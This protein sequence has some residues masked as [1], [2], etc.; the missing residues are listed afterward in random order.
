MAEVIKGWSHSVC[1]DC[2]WDDYP[3]VFEAGELLIP[4]WPTRVSSQIGCRAACC[5]CGQTHRSGIWRRANPAEL[6]NCA[7]YEEGS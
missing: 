6:P 7:G 4:R 2:W 1:W 5:F 3:P